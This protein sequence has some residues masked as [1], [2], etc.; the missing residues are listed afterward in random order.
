[1]SKNSNLKQEDEISKNLKI[2]EKPKGSRKQK[3]V[4]N[5]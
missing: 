3:S 2:I 4:T 5:S 1:M